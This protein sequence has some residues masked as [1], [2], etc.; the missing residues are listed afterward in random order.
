MEKEQLKCY[1][2]K[3]LILKNNKLEIRGKDKET[4]NSID[5][6][7]LSEESEDVKNILNELSKENNENFEQRLKAISKNTTSRYVYMILTNFLNNHIDIERVFDKSIQLKIDIGMH[8]RD[9]IESLYKEIVNLIEFKGF[10]ILDDGE[11]P[12]YED[13]TEFYNKK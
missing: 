4:Y 1:F 8:D 5:Y 2:E 9:N 7:V 3:I 12:Y 13:M 6:S 11:A 10:R